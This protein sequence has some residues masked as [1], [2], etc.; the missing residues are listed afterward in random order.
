MSVVPPS[1][2]WA[3]TRTSS[4]PSDLDLDRRGDAGGDRRGVAEQR[5]DPRNLPRGFGVGRRED[6]EAAGGVGR[7]QLVVGGVH[8]RV[9]GVTRAER[10]AAALAGAVSRVQGVGSVDQVVVK[11]KEGERLQGV[12]DRSV[13]H[14]VKR[15][16]E[17]GAT[18]ESGD[19]GVVGDRVRGHRHPDVG[20]DDPADAHRE[21]LLDADE[22][23]GASESLADGLQREWAE[24]RNAQRANLFAALATFVDDVLDRAEHRAQRDDHGLGV[25]EAIAAHEAT[26][27]ATKDFLELRGDPRNDIERLHLPVVGEVT[28]LGEGLGPDHRA[29]GYRLVGVEDLARLEGRQE[30]GDV[31]LFGDVDLLDCVGEDEPIHAD[32]DRQ[33][34][35]LGDLEG[36]DVQVSRL[37]VGLGIQLDPPG[38]ALAHRVGVVIPD[39]DRG[40]DGAVGDR[41]DDRQPEP[42]RVVDRFDH[43]QQALARGRGVGPRASCR[44]ANRDRHGRELALDVDVFT[45]REF[46]RFDDGRQAFD[47]VCL[48]RDRV[49]AN[50]VRATGSHRARDRHRALNLRAHRWSPS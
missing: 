34:E 15:T 30:L 28:N 3:T 9:D 24:G 32:H 46:A 36:L 35:L 47:D 4:R 16:L 48:G 22:P 8:R 2:P 41:H 1:P 13:E 45:P 42:G 21:C 40:A 26:R 29:D 50:H 37:L 7:D 38:V 31:S 5:V 14:P 18:T 20:G 49:G 33:R 43:E 19:D 25:V 10:L 23:F 6:L 39:V 12:G 27:V 44:G 17:D 11:V